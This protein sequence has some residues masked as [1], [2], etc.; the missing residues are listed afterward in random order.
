MRPEAPHEQHDHQG[1]PAEDDDRGGPVLVH[2]AERDVE[3]AA[4]REEEVDVDEGSGEREEDLLHG[5]GAEHRDEADPDQDRDHDQEHERSDVGGQD[6]VQRDGDGIAGEDVTPFHPP[7]VGEAED[8]EPGER[9]R[10]RLHD[11]QEDRGDQR[12][13]RD[14]RDRVPEIV[15]PASEI[16]AEQVRGRADHHHDQRPHDQ[17]VPQWPPRASR[18]SRCVLRG[19]GHAASSAT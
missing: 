13:C 3:R 14:R 12:G 8:R 5:V 17:P 18:R 19:D 15:E 6:P 1:S 9:R 7:G 2:P 4:D 11:H 10:G 16:P